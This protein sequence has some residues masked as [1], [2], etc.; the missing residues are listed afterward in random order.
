MLLWPTARPLHHATMRGQIETAQ[1]LLA[2]NADVNAKSKDGW[3]PFKMAVMANSHNELAELL[4]AHGAD[5]NTK[6]Q[7]GLTPLH[8]AAFLG[9]KDA[10]EFLLAHKADVN[11][12]T[13]KGE[14][15]LD[16]TKKMGHR[17]SNDVAE[18]LRQH[19]GH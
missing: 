10:V 9:Q 2:H 16:M 11:A 3:T 12:K 8:G 19:G 18:L 4:L 1:V 6:D 17:G 7:F 13:D 5:V 14:T 15:P